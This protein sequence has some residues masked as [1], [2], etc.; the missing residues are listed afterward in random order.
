MNRHLQKR[1]ARECG[2]VLLT[3]MLMVALLTLGLLAMV[4]NI[5]SQIRRDREEELIHRGVQYSRAV[6]LFFARFKRY[7]ASID[8]LES[9]NNMRFLRKRYKDPITGKDFK[10]LYMND[11]AAFN[12]LPVAPVTTAP[13]PLQASGQAGSNAPETSS[14]QGDE[15]AGGASSDSSGQPSGPAPA[16]FSDQ[17]VENQADVSDTTASGPK[18]AEAD[19]NQVPLLHGVPIVGVASSSRAKTIREFNKQDHYNQWQFIYDPTTAHVGL[20]NTPN[21]PVLRGTAQ[22]S[23]NGTNTAQGPGLSPGET[24]PPSGALNQ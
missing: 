16:D 10:V 9:T 1:S 3:L 5:E 7:P 12:R 21:Q 14:A 24:N 8:E 19:P 15:S 11:V 18:S 22:P 2:Y 4:Q 23:Q 13:T 6:R 17:A 20:I